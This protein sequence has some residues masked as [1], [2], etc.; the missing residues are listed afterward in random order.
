MKM[1]FLLPCIIGLL[2]GSGAYGAQLEN[3]GWD[4]PDEP[5]QIE[6]VK[7]SYISCNNTGI[8]WNYVDNCSEYENPIC[9]GW[10]NESGSY[11]AYFGTESCKTCNTNYLRVT[12]RVP[13]N[14]QIIYTETGG[15]GFVGKKTAG[16]CQWQGCDACFALAGDWATVKTGYERRYNYACNETEQTCSRNINYTYRCAAGWYKSSGGTGVTST[17]RCTQNPLINSMVCSGC[18]QCP[19]HKDGTTPTSAAGSTD[20]TDCYVTTNQTWTE[21]DASGTKT[22]RFKSTCSYKENE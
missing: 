9:Y 12:R 14:D 2:A 16:L 17:I 20:I 11:T 3:P 1:F 7:Q 6:M 21:T 8:E 18:S 5:E 22:S 15:V 19:N 10:Q 13:D 4:L